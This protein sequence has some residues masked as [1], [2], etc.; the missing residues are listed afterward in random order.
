M[1]SDFNKRYEA[2]QSIPERV[3]AFRPHH[4]PSLDEIKLQQ[5]KSEI[6]SAVAFISEDIPGEREYHL[7]HQLWQSQHLVDQH[8]RE[9]SYY[10]QAR[11]QLFGSRSPV[12]THTSASDL[13]R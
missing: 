10:E 8:A 4:E 5:I 7:K 2:F 1:V 9:E 3:D 11:Q 6:Q 13:E 12:E